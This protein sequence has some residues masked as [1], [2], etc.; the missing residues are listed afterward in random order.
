M[1]FIGS[2][3]HEL[4]IDPLNGGRVVSWQIAGVDVLAPVENEPIEGGWYL[5]APWVGR[6][7]QQKI[8]FESREY[9]QSTNFKNWAIH[10]TLPFAECRV[11]AHSDTEV[12]ISH[13]TDKHWPIPALVTLAWEV[14]D[15]GV[16][17]R[18]SVSTTEGNF[19]AAVGW[20]PWFRRNLL[21]GDDVVGRSAVYGFDAS[22]QFAVDEN[23]IVS[24]DTIDVGTSPFDDSFF[25]ADGKAH[26]SWPG[27]RRIDIDADVQF[28][29]LY[30]S[31]NFVCIEPETAPPNGVNLLEAGFGH[32]VSP[33]RPL[34]AHAEWR[35]S[36]HSGLN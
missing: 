32:I 35:V 10:G 36:V 30:E 23:F 5:M 15:W 9:P 12:V 7:D 20:H 11:L 2:G 13:S 16:E 27:F 29:H 1:L 26:I 24:G 3:E 17:T 19:P 18:A 28:M 33:G 34:T 25:V 6:L 22:T 8:V 14:H 21:L 4:F 31:E